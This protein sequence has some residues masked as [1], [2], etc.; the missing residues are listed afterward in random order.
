[1]ITD[2]T[3]DNTTDRTADNRT[4][5]TLAD[6]L[7]IANVQA[8]ALHV[9]DI[10]DTVQN[11]ICIVT[12]NSNIANRSLTALADTLPISMWTLYPTLD[13]IRDALIDGDKKRAMIHIDSAVLDAH[14]MLRICTKRLLTLNE[15]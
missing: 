1:M 3:T 13:K 5:H 8:D 7:I 11:N 10:L 6:V 15:D 12:D 9:I 4:A 14:R 2:N